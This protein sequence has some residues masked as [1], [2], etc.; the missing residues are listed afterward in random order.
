MHLATCAREALV[1]CGM[2]RLIVLMADK[3]SSHLRVF[4]VWGLPKEVFDLTFNVS[5]SNGL[6]HLMAQPAQ[7]RLTPDN[8]AVIG[9]ALPDRL[10][11]LFPGEHL[12]MR[13]LSNNGRVVMLML[14]DQGAWVSLAMLRTSAWRSCS[15]PMK[16]SSATG[17]RGDADPV[18]A[19]P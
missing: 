8:N 2:R 17:P 3:T 15:R 13:S 7:L 16:S 4:Q 18:R 14:A 5:E 12:L 10:R 19:V 9:A 6:Q 11:R 1:A